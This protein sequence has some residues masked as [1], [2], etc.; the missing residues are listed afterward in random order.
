MCLVNKE[1]MSH[2]SPNTTGRAQSSLAVAP[3]NALSVVYSVTSNC[4]LRH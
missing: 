3:Q 2:A 1:L 4:D